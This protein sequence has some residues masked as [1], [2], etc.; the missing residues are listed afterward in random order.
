ML[1][2]ASAIYH[3]DT[4]A[5]AM[6]ADLLDRLDARGVGFELAR[7]TA[8]VRDTLR[9][10]GSRNGSA[11]A[12]S[13]PRCE[14]RVASFLCGSGVVH[15]WGLAIVALALLGYA[16]LSRRLDRT[17]VTGPMVFVGVGLA[18]GAAGT[19]GCTRNLRTSV[20]KARRRG[21][22]SRSSSSPTPRGSTCARCAASSTSP[23]G[24]SGSACR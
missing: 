1:V 19:A 23:R 5:A 15:N 18:F 11:A 9:R 6:L 2:D 20:V 16:G 13:T 3:V 21:R 12:P 10:T 4:T 24:C 7:A 8:S 14:P 17:I 22:R